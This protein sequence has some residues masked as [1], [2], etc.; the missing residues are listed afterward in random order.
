MTA[1]VFME[2]FHQGTGRR[3]V[4]T[5]RYVEK[6]HIHHITF[7]KVYFYN[8]FILLS[9]IIANLLLCLIDKL[10]LVIGRYVQEKS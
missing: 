10:Q 8:C 6:E 5:I 2:L 3:G 9:D 7:I 4:S 1:I